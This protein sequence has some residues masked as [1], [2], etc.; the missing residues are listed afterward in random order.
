MQ[1]F[2]NSGMRRFSNSP[3][4][5]KKKNDKTAQNCKNNHFRTLENDQRH[6]RNGEAVI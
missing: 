5:K 2:Q 4:K 3:Q 1:N 6:T